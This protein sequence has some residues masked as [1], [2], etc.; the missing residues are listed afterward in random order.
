[1]EWITSVDKL[2][3]EKNKVD[4]NVLDLAIKMAEEKKRDFVK[5]SNEIIKC[6]SEKRR[7]LMNEALVLEQ[8]S[9]G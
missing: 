2:V 6:L 8:R 3:I 1:M 7:K 5:N 4:V 9:R